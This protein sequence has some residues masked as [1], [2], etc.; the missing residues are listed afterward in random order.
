MNMRVNYIFLAGLLVIFIGCTKNKVE[1]FSEVKNI[2]ELKNT[3]FLPTLESPLTKGKNSIYCSTLLLSWDLVRTVLNGDLK[4]D[5]SNHDL[6]MLN[7]STSFLNSL[8]KDEYTS[9]VK[10]KNSSIE[11][12]VEFSKSLPFANDLVDLGT[13][14]TF[15]KSHVQSFGVS[16]ENEQVEILYYKNDSDFVI[17]LQTK[18]KANELILYRIDKTF[19]TLI[20]AIQSVDLKIIEGVFDRA[21]NRYGNYSFNKDDILKVPKLKFNIESTFPTMSNKFVYNNETALPVK[22]MYQRTAFNLNEKGV[23][24]ESEARTVIGEVSI[25]DQPDWKPKNLTFDKP[26][27]LILRKTRTEY[28]YFAMWISNDELMLK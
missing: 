22:E 27:I 11:V 1:R 20:Q 6:F 28:P 3:E 24:I 2:D 23:E 8:T 18:D 21:N 13:S 17:K 10:V 15:N 7:K 16:G 25:N 5:S 9:S 12:N 4:V 19:E 14:L 26:F